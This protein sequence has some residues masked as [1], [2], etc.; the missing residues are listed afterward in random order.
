VNGKILKHC[1]TGA[2]YNFRTDPDLG[3]GIVAV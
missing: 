3:I 2:M 1:G